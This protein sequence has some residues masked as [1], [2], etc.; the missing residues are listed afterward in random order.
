MRVVSRG[1]V[2]TCGQEMQIVQIVASRVPAIRIAA[3][4]DQ[5]NWYD[6]VTRLFCFEESRFVALRC[7]ERKSARLSTFANAFWE[8]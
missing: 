1:Q 5:V 8:S 6:Q 4:C 2:M 7:G 3:W